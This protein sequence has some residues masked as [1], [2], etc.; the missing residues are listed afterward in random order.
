MAAPLIVSAD[1][2]ARVLDHKALVDALAEAF[3]SDIQ[4]PPKLAH[5]IPQPSG[6]AAK[7]L[8]MP[9][10]TTAASGDRF[11]GC[12]LVSVF[13]DNAQAGLSSVY[14]NYLLMSG[15]TGETLAVSSGVSQP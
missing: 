2:I 7:F 15:L 10:W 12:K 14:G 11:I 8:L 5:M 9:A 4:A 3:R 1:D 6:N 13:P